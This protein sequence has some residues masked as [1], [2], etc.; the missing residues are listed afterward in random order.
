MPKAKATVS[1]PSQEAEENLDIGEQ[2]EHTAT[3]LLALDDL[4]SLIYLGCLTET[5]N[6]GNYRFDVCTL[7]TAQQR[8]V[9]KKIMAD[10]NATERMLDIKP[11]TM[12][13]ATRTVNGVPLESLSSL[14]DDLPDT[15]RRLDVMM[16]LQSIVIEKLYQVYDSLVTKSGKEIGIDDLKG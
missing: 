9:M 15:E 12:A 16:N 7:T 11:L 8:D 2:V 1:S 4:K 13:Y 14:P 6:I 10:G 3:D 5:V